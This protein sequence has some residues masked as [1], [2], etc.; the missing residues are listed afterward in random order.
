M[1]ESQDC[2]FEL[3]EDGIAWVT[4]NRPDSLNA[5]GGRIANGPVGT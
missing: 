1:V 5:I 4:H 2:L 3:R